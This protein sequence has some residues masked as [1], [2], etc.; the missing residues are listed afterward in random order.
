MA[1]TTT[2]RASGVSLDLVKW[3]D[4]QAKAQCTNRSTI[5][6]QIIAQRI[7]E[8]SETRD[9]QSSKEAA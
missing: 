7:A 1:N 9:Q 3:I 8:E 2:I 6:R 5:I 4:E